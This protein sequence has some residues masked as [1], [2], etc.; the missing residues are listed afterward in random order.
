MPT[1]NVMRNGEVVEVD[2]A[3][4]APEP[5]PP[6]YATAEEAR[7]AMVGWIDSL[8]AQVMDQYPKAVQARWEIEEAA[9]RAVKAG[10]ATTAQT[11]LVTREGSAKSRTPVEHADAIIANADRFRAIADQINTLFLATDAALQAATDPYQYEV[12]LDG[13]IAQAQPLAQAYNLSL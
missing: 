4:Y 3:A 11:E 8:T 6:E 9:A 7:L 2:A 10:T 12:I 5:R 1:V 13:A